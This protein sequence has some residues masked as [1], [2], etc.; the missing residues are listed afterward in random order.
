M[1]LK[2]LWAR[3]ESLAA[4]CKEMIYKAEGTEK[5]VFSDEEMKVYNEKKLEL[6]RV[7]TQ[8]D[9]VQGFEMDDKTNE[10]TPLVAA[11]KVERRP[12]R[13]PEAVKEFESMDEWLGTV[14]SNPNDQ[15]LEWQTYQSEQRMDSGAAGGF[16]IPKQFLPEIRERAFTEAV[17]R[18]RATVIS[19]GTPPD[20]E[21]SF[22]VLQQEPDANG[23]HRIYGGV[24]VNKV[25]EGGQKP[26]TGFELREVALKPHEIA[27]IIPMTDKLLRNWTA[28]SGWASRL[29]RE[30]MLGFEDNEFLKGNGIGGP[31][32]VLDSG[33][34]YVVNRA[35]STQ[36]GLADL[37]EMYARF[38][39]NEDRAF[40][41]FS[42]GAFRFLLN[43]TG[44]GGGAT[45][46]IDIDRS[47]GNVN[48]YGIPVVRTS[49]MRAL[50]QKGDV[51]IMDLNDYIIK[52]GSGPIVEVG[53]DDGQFRSNKRSIKV[54][55]NVDAKY[56]HTKPYKE[57]ENYEISSVVVLD[58]PSGS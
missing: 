47:T 6:D 54:T 9:L 29:L 17:V 53:Y 51:A 55:W 5:G 34:A 3:K 40:W 46:I 45:N 25:A 1:D 44:D 39:G 35:T 30:A 43:I 10:K 13:G 12:I 37:K 14:L 20:A 31:S 23:N 49:R 33:G 18:P 58:V 7:K 21:I 22:P 42:R 27:A 38:S 19:A 57:E 15:R 56:L 36:V 41:G 24:E 28:A 11:S 16:A 4:E 8:I 26:L 32:G 50:G 2:N 52:D 48:I